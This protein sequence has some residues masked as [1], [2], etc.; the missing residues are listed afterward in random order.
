M[1]KADQEAFVKAYPAK[2]K[3]DNQHIVAFSKAIGGLAKPL[4]GTIDV[5]SYLK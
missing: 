1:K 4:A 3:S 5:R 2:V